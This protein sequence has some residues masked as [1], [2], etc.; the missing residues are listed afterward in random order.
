MLD[1]NASLHREHVTSSDVVVLAESYL[2]PTVCGH[3]IRFSEWNVL[4]AT[5]HRC[6]ICHWAVSY[7]A[8][9]VAAS[10]LASIGDTKAPTTQNAAHLVYFKYGKLAYHLSV[11]NLG[12]GTT[13]AFPG[14]TDWWINPFSWSL[15]GVVSSTTA[16]QRIASALGI[17]LPHLKVISLF[18]AKP[19]RLLTK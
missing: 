1:T 13:S 10:M 18:L 15:R 8:D 19:K 12:G 4:A 5:T 9:G 7:I 17:S 14:W 2:N 6:P 3:S 11:P 16:Q